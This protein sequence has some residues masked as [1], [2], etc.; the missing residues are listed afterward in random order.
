MITDLGA[1]QQSLFNRHHSDKHFSSFLPTRW[2]Q[3]STGTLY[4]TKLRHCHPVYVLR[5]KAVGYRLSFCT[6][7]FPGIGAKCCCER[8]CLSASY[9]TKCWGFTEE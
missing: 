2:R 4:E 8:G 5:L 6:S 3:K 7:S 1:Y 9:K